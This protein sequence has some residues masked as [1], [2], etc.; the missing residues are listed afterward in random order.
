MLW[1]DP[2]IL[3]FVRKAGSASCSANGIS[4]GVGVLLG[5]HVNCLLHVGGPNFLKHFSCFCGFHVKVS[6]VTMTCT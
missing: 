6:E 2:Q 5:V 1:P 4:G 3:S